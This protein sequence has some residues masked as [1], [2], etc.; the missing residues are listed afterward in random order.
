MNSLITDIDYALSLLEDR[1]VF[2]D[3]KEHRAKS[4]IRDLEELKKCFLSK[5]LDSYDEN[6]IGYFRGPSPYEDM[7]KRKTH[8]LFNTTLKILNGLSI[9][10]LE[11]IK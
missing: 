1:E 11:N 7:Y 10:R 5:N 8:D 9:C 6:K 4:F 2:E 3:L